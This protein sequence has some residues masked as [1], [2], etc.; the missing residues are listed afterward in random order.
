MF[1]NFIHPDILFQSHLKLEKMCPICNN[2]WFKSSH[3]AQKFDLLNISWK[4]NKP[5][6]SRWNT[7]FPF[8]LHILWI[9]SIL[10]NTVL[11]EASKKA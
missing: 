4:Q 5:V 8:I 2:R 3:R 11:T 6:L 9:Y 1:A 10:D 7:L